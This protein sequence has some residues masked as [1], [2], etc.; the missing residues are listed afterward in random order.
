MVD[1]NTAVG[2]IMSAADAAG[3]FGAIKK[4]AAI[5][6][7]RLMRAVHPDMDPSEEA[8]AA[9]SRLNALWEEWQADNGGKPTSPAAS[10]APATKTKTKTIKVLST[11]EATLFKTDDGWLDV[12]NKPGGSSVDSVEDFPCRLGKLHKMVEGSPVWAPSPDEM[13]AILVAQ[14]DGQH[15]AIKIKPGD[16]GMVDGWPLAA[17]GAVDERDLAW[18]LKRLVFL[19]S[20]MCSVGITVPDLCGRVMVRPS[21]HQIGVASFTGAECV[22]KIDGEHDPMVS[23]MDSF[24]KLTAHGTGSGVRRLSAFAEGCKVS[25]RPDGTELMRELDDV[26]FDL[27]GAPRFHGMEDPASH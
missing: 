6:Y 24:I 26:L 18:I 9:A 19:G 7:R 10:H 4:R 2:E 13:E 15:A 3:L 20:A 14:K 12:A 5:K 25:S 8:S 23:L 11:T 27:Y 21:T 1:P 16:H 22:D 17:L